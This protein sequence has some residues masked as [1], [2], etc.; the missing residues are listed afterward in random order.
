MKKTNKYLIL[1]FGVITIAFLLFY[2]FGVTNKSSSNASLM[3]NISYAV[4]EK[5]DLK[6]SDLLDWYRSNYK[7]KGV[8]SI[9]KDENTFILLSTG[10]QSTGGYSIKI[11]SIKG[12]K[13]YLKINGKVN[14]PRPTQMTTQAETYPNII[15]IVPKEEREIILGNFNLY[16]IYGMKNK[17]L[18]I[19]PVGIDTALLTKIDGYSV[20]IKYTRID[21]KFQEIRLSEKAKNIIEHN[22]IEKDSLITFE[23]EIKDN[24]R[25]AQIT[26]IKEIQKNRVKASIYNVDPIEG[27]V[28]LFIN[29]SKYSLKYA[30]KIADKL[31]EYYNRNTLA[32]LESRVALVT[33]I[34]EEGEIIVSDIL[35]F[36]N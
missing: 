14:P 10:E 1:G 23:Y 8:Y 28:K 21:D 29:N 12:T 2:A 33:L 18:E 25:Y 16:D 32:T 20:E 17:N 3:G 24:G 9:T 13:N 35:L 5:N 4:I 27:E 11:D 34:E 22:Q 26:N 7:E 6:D 31:N 19:P 36:K 15:L 30:K